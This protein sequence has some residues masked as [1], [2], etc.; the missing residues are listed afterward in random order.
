M[1]AVEEYRGR[2]EWGWYQPAVPLADAAIAELEAQILRLKDEVGD[3]WARA[4]QAEAKLSGS[5][6][7]RTMLADKLEQ[8][9]ADLFD[10]IYERGVTE[11][12]KREVEARWARLRGWAVEGE[13]W[14]VTEAMDEAEKGIS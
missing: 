8:A 7:Y 9:E 6:T 14:V 13:L 2:R 4:G 10:Q 1:S 12:G 3:E 11:G 5:E